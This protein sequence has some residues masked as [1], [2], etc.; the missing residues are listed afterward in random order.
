MKNATTSRA[1]RILQMYI[2]LSQGKVIDK[3]YA[4]NIYHVDI[5]T[6]QRDISSINCMLSE[7][8]DSNNGYIEVKFNSYLGGYVMQGGKT[9]DKYS[10]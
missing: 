10:N 2:V 6:I 1:E 8:L 3:Y 7:S 4:A 5:R 9:Y